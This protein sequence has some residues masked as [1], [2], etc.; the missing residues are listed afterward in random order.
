MS[1]LRYT[2]KDKR[3]SGIVEKLNSSIKSFVG[4]R[5]NIHTY[6][7]KD[8]SG[9]A[10]VVYQTDE[11]PSQIYFCR[12][13]SYGDYDK[14]SKYF[15]DIYDPDHGIEDQ[16]FGNITYENE[17][18]YYNTETHM[19]NSEPISFDSY[20]FSL[21]NHNHFPPYTRTPGLNFVIAGLKPN[22]PYKINIGTIYFTAKTEDPYYESEKNI[23]SDSHLLGMLFANNE[24]SLYDK[25][26]FTDLSTYDGSQYV[27]NLYF[28]ETVQAKHSYHV[29]VNYDN[30]Y[31]DR[32]TPFVDY[33]TY[34]ACTAN[35]I[36][37][38][39]E[40]PVGSE[41]VNTDPF[42]V[43]AYS[44]TGGY[45]NLCLILE[46]IQQPCYIS[47]WNMSVEEVPFDQSVRDSVLQL[48][49]NSYPIDA[50]KYTV[51]NPGS[52]ILYGQENPK[53]Y[54]GKNGDI[55]VT[56]L[57]S[58]DLTYRM[59]ALSSG[60]D[61]I[62]T[63]NS[64]ELW[65]STINQY[66]ISAQSRSDATPG[67][68]I[69]DEEYVDEPYIKVKFT[70]LNTD[71]IYHIFVDR[72]NDA[73]RSTT[74]LNCYD[75]T[76]MDEYLVKYEKEVLYDKP[77][78]A[79][80][81]QY[82]IIDFYFR[83]T[84]STAIMR[85]PTA[86]IQLTT[87]TRFYQTPLIA[88]WFIT[89]KTVV[90]NSLWFKSDNRWCMLSTGGG[91]GSSVS[92]TP[93]VSTGVKIADFSIDGTPGELY[94]PYEEVVANPQLPEPPSTDLAT[95]KIG[96]SAYKIDSGSEV[97]FESFLHSGTI[98]GRLVI[99]NVGYDLYAPEGGGG[100]GGDDSTMLTE[101]TD[102]D[103]IW[104]VG[105]DYIDA[106]AEVPAYT[107]THDGYANNLI[108]VM[109][110]NTL[111]S[112]TAS[113]SSSHGSY[114]P[115]YAFNPTT[116]T[117]WLPSDSDNTPYLAYTWPSAVTVRRLV[118]SMYSEASSTITRQI[119]VEGSND[120]L[121]WENCLAVGTYLTL[122]F[123]GNYTIGNVLATL[124]AHS[125]NAIRIRDRNSQYWWVN[126]QYACFIEDMCVY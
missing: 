76:F 52:E 25:G 51:K 73:A 89:V 84:S 27:S 8:R 114:P 23:I 108:P 54:L 11:Y 55:Y 41:D 74:G 60:A 14:R 80:Y 87:P 116:G 70:N 16:L 45:I 121:N 9:D 4:F 113:A 12:G 29:K 125:Y 44:N 20:V 86:D 101:F 78:S 122:D 35:G 93:R 42:Y 69:V 15:T 26:N 75:K 30:G 46:A 105:G 10:K 64:V 24:R 31:I 62:W 71:T 102:M 94:S 2:G 81:I 49:F 68:I 65:D 1:L 34:G 112:G 67:D 38:A 88:D 83:P 98:I 22:M 72:H 100:G 40:R 28:D 107:E 66:A 79:T 90:P 92:I 39:L 103:R 37:Y 59:E 117:R 106:T 85:I 91:G 50:D 96:S 57:E 53:P 5:D 115:Y 7:S 77:G 48:T 99:D 95:I 47:I 6:S 120:G 56:C 124:N 118:I 18:L 21:Q 17:E 43:R 58:Y 13:L 3:F 97:S 19:Y 61:Y 32:S 63:F 119:Y 36:Y 82:S 109:T 33:T 123:T 104:S 111:P 110:S 126:G